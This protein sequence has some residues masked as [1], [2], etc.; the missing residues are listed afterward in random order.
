MQM[1]TLFVLYTTWKFGCVIMQSTGV[2][3]LIQISC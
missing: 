1:S 2:S 3:Q